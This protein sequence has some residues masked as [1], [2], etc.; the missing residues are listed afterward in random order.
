LVSFFRFT[1]LQLTA[2]RS[3]R[4]AVEAMDVDSR[5]FDRK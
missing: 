4:R 2:S 1:L 3:I 5:K